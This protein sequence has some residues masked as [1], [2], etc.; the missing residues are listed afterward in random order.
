M[1]VNKNAYLRYIHIH[2]QIKRNK[3]KPGY[4][5]KQH[6]LW[7]LEEEGMK[8]S[9]SQLEKDM[10]FLRYERGAPIEYDKKQ[11]CYSYSEDWE[12]DIPL[13]PDIISTI[14]MLVHK[15]QPFG[16]AQEFRMI[17]DTLDR[18]SEQF[19]LSFR[20][21][22]EK[23]DK[24]ILFEYTKGFAGRH[25]LPVIYDAIFESRAIDFTHCKFNSRESTKR[26]LQPYIL[27]EHRNRWYVIGKEEGETKIF[28]LD[29]ISDLEVTDR[30]FE[31]DNDFYDDIFRVLY[32]SVGVMA[33]GFPSEEVVLEFDKS[34][35]QYVETLML[36]RSQVITSLDGGRISVAMKVKVTPEFIMECILRFG[37]HVRVVKPQHLAGKVTEVYR[38]ALD[39]Y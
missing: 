21:S 32:D 9:G 1:P 37:S 19:N 8:V 30:Y 16:E 3:F 11:Q 27:K 2:S 20:R 28:G 38:Q 15:L 14:R 18:L 6:L 34:Q 24:Y 26:T 17:K 4:P 22:V 31:K 12:F 7:S 39:N 35:A 10:A 5:T 29:R 13:T 25:H 36:H 33:F 23:L